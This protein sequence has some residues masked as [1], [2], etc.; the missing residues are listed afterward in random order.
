M[1][2]QSNDRHIAPDI[3]CY[4]CGVCVAVCPQRIIRM[5]LNDEGFYTPAIER[6]DLCTECGLC[7]SVCAYA[8]DRLPQPSAVRASYAAWSLDPDI[9]RTASS[10]GVGY[11]LARNLAAR[12]Y[13]ACGVRYDP[14]RQRAEHFIADTTDA[15]RASMGSKYIPSYT[16]SAFTQLNRTDRFFVTGTPCQIDSLRRYIRRLRIEDHFVL[17]D[18]F[19]HGVPSM[20]LWKKYLGEVEQTVG[21]TGAVAWR[22]KEL[23]WQNSW[24]MTAQGAR[25][26]YFSPLRQGDLFY[27]FFLGNVCLGRA[28]YDRCK[29][30]MAQSAADIRIGDLWGPTYADDR[31]GVSGVLVFTPRGE[32]ALAALHTECRFEP[33]APKTIMEGQM[34]R[35]PRK[36]FVYDTVMQRLRGPKPLRATAPLIAFYRWMILPRRIFHRILRKLQ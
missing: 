3:P 8:D 27:K 20:N 30:K 5:R 14:E 10:G 16:P 7:L 36:P 13:K 28:C 32:E 4:G 2:K 17:M 12:G 1:V 33:H 24:I 31:Q 11:A 26:P 25:G 22:N 34:L 9:R 35:A 29:Y 19:C 23:G 21:R 18:F 15:L 6:E